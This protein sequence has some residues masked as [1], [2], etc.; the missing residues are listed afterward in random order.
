MKM[1]GVRFNRTGIV[2]AGLG[3]LVGLSYADSLGNDFAYDD[4]TQIVSNDLLKK[5]GSLPKLLTSDYWA[6]RHESRGVVP[7]SSGLYRPVVHLSLALNYGLGGLNPLG[8]HLVNVVLHLF[9]TWVLYLLACRLGFSLTAAG[10]AAALFAVHPLHTEAV[11]GIV[12]RAELLMALGVLASWWLAIT[13]RRWWSLGA[14]L[15]ALF[16]KEQAM[17][18]PVLLLLSDVCRGSVGM[19]A[20]PAGGERRRVAANAARRYGPYLMALAAYLAARGAVLGGVTVPPAAFVENPLGSVDG[21]TRILTA[22][23]VAGL[24]LWLCV[25]PASLSADYSYNSIPF[26]HSP[27]DLGVLPAILAWGGLIGL[28]VWTVRKRDPAP[29]L[30]VALTLLTFAPVS[31][32][33]V[34]IGTIMGERLFYLPSAGLCLL[35]GLGL[36]RGLRWATAHNQK[37]VRKIVPIGMWALSCAICLM[38]LGRTVV[39]NQDWASTELLSRR[40]IE[41]APSNA[42]A[43]TVL[44]HELKRTSDKGALERALEHYQ[45]ALSIYPEYIE[46]DPEFATSIGDVLFRLG[47]T[48]EALVLLQQAFRREPFYGL[49]LGLAYVRLGEP[50]NAERVWREALAVRVHE[51]EIRSRL[52]LLLI[53]RGRYGE[54]LAAAEEVLGR[55]PDFVL[56]LVS[57]A[58][59]L[60]ALGKHEAAAAAYELVLNV[61]DVPAAARR[62]VQRRLKEI[63]DRSG[64][65]TPADQGCIPG[66]LLCGTRKS[67]S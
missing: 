17:V 35:A 5:P 61:R 47:R 64:G 56:A 11:A 30:S 32:V 62:D 9:V 45:T 1:A 13:G 65:E 28:A 16:S 23:K 58:A 42:K 36:A 34:P 51:P 44:A 31:N 3:L 57:R 63:R 21:A 20:A 50:E 6:V 4:N 37:M 53:E 8:Y 40:A 26:A 14:F 7:Y 60:E 29:S 46:H 52:S 38:G 18:M 12:G 48:T 19:P 66:T 49:Y 2:L 33:I 10:S 41:V 24:Y 67:R 54:A 39:R 25:W 22:I 43:H 55:H 59:A 27:L 15:M